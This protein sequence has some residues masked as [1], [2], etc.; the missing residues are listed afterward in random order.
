M[1]FP[2]LLLS[3]NLEIII[4]EFISGMYHQVSKDI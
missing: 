3:R 4:Y 1:S 2:N